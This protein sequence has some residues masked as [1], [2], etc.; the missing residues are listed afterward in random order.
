MNAAAM[1]RPPMVFGTPEKSGKG[2]ADYFSAEGQAARR[3]PPVPYSSG[4]R[5]YRR[6]RRRCRAW[7]VCSRSAPRSRG[8]SPPA[9][10]STTPPTRTWCGARSRSA[11]S[12]RRAGERGVGDTPSSRSCRRRVALRRRTRTSGS[13]CCSLRWPGRRSAPGR[14]GSGSRRPCA[15]ST[16]PTRAP[17]RGDPPRRRA[18]WTS[19]SSTTCDPEPMVGL[20]DAMAR[21]CRARLD[22]LGR[23]LRPDLRDRAPGAGRR[24]GRRARGARGDRRA[25]RLLA[26]T[27]DTLIARKRGAEAAARVSANA[28]DVLRAEARVPR[29][30]AGAAELRRVAA[31]ARRRAEPRDHGDLVTATCCSSRCSRVCSDAIRTAQSH[32]S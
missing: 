27:P 7:P 31:R 29:P 16:W 2:P 4:D 6:H 5:S 19:A 11:R 24:A 25:V 22:R 9:T 14:C 3:R 8:T 32:F 17:V 12:W 28:G 26:A 1:T 15:R 20:R 18:A 30:P 21:R 10:I 13:R 23:R